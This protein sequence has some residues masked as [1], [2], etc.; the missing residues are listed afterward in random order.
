MNKNK[1]I[2]AGVTE[3]N[4]PVW[5]GA[6]WFSETYGLPL[7]EILYKLNKENIVIDWMD[8]YISARDS[9]IIP[10]R[11]FERMSHAIADVLGSKYRDKVLERLKYLIYI[12]EI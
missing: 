11:I 7:T 10:E 12:E 8:Y 4:K 1:F 9:G 2:Q 3:D 6:Y 5:K